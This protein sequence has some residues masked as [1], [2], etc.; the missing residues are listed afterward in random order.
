MAYEID[1]RDVKFQL[2]DWLDLES[3]LASEVFADWDRENIE[4][5]LGEALK[6]AKEQLDPANEPGDRE[7]VALEDGKVTVPA[8][9]QEPFKTLAD[10]GWVGCV[11]NPEFGGLGLPHLVSLAA[12][13]FFSGANT[14]LSLVLL[15]TRGVGELVE[16]YGTDELRQL[17]C[18]KLYA[19]TWTGTM[20][21]T[22][23]QAGSDVGGVHDDG[24]TGRGRALQHRR[25]EDLHHLRR[26][27]YDRQCRP[28][29]LGSTARGAGW[30]QGT[31][32]LSRAE[33]PRQ[34]RWHPG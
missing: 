10:G 22:E 4:L 31:L 5:V 16:T 14:S 17:Y 24:R 29:R 33:V 26:S 28:R 27:R 25:R 13:E 11:N 8:A 19:G 1:I 7:G 32:A 18:E 21:L 15:L 34:A 6:I 2:F 30:H 12:N 9:Y 3:I 23:P 20:C